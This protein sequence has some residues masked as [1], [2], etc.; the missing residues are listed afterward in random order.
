MVYEYETLPSA[1]SIRILTLCPAEQHTDAFECTIEATELEE[2]SYDALSYS[3]GMN[4]DGN[5]SQDYEMFIHDNRKWITR[6]LFE[7]LKRIR[8]RDRPIRIW[9]DAVCINQQDDVERSVQVAMMAD[10]YARAE[11]VLVWLGNGTEEKEDLAM[12]GLLERIKKRTEQIM[13]WK[14][15]FGEYRNCFVLPFLSEDSLPCSGCEAYQQ[16]KS[17]GGDLIQ[18]IAHI[19]WLKDC[20]RSDHSLEQTAVDMTNMAIRF[21]SRRYWKRRW[22]LQEL[23][24]SNTHHWYW[25]QHDLDISKFPEKWIEDLV[26]AIWIVGHVLEETSQDLTR[27]AARPY[28]T[29]LIDGVTVGSPFMTRT[30]GL[31]NLCNSQNHDITDEKTWNGLL[32]YFHSSECSEPKDM[33]YALASMAIPRIRID[34][35]LT[36]AQVF[37]QF[38]EIMLNNGEWIWVFYCA[39]KTPNNQESLKMPSWVPD[40]RLVDFYYEG[41]EP[42][43]GIQIC[44]DSL[45][46][47]VRCLGVLRTHEEVNDDPDTYWATHDFHLMWDDLF[48][49][50]CSLRELL[51]ES[52][53]NIWP[54]PLQP[55]IDSDN[56]RSGDILCSCLEEP[57]DSDVLII[58]RRKP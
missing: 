32:S 15:L 22:I 44:Q 10:I 37:Q 14:G 6:N 19:D 36:V 25:G 52:S 43:M 17:S 34:Y 56:V 45:V 49:Q 13:P 7:G 3:W 50:V 41:R 18:D 51:D 26:Q 21:F 30:L 16:S 20:F 33:Y 42:P 40:P 35:S 58:L 24:L 23:S 9:I 48:W 28:S 5:S 55:R 53:E 11:K 29:V 39:A 46:C 4:E 27:T 8:V 38:A 31:S 47:D 1:R 2:A 12:L 54:S 57:T